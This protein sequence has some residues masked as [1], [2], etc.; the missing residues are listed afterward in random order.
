[1]AESD[2][3]REYVDIALKYIKSIIP[4]NNVSMVQ[5]DNGCWGSKPER[6]VDNYVPDIY[7]VY[8]RLKIIGEA[9]TINDCMKP[10]SI[11]QYESYINDCIHFDGESHIIVVTSIYSVPCICNFF[12]N[13]KNKHGLQTFFHILGNIKDYPPII[14]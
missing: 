5:V 4:E 7:F 10:H 13:K 12:K 2:D 6:T 9:K 14:F 1:M 11:S 3:H 8:N